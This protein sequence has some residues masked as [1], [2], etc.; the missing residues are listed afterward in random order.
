MKITDIQ[1]KKI[2]N[3]KI[4]GVANIVIDDCFAIHNIRIMEK[5]GKLY[6]S[7]PSKE[8]QPNEKIIY[9]NVCHPINQETRDEMESKILEEFNKIN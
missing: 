6:L 7:F 4:K 9:K 5:E 2:E 8:F 3:S 1:V